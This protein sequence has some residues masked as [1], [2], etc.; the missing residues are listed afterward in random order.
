[1]AWILLDDSS[2][3]SARADAERCLLELLDL[4]SNYFPNALRCAA[5]S[6]PRWSLWK[7]AEIQGA[8]ELLVKPSSGEA[9]RR[10]LHHQTAH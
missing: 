8:H 10:I 3:G 7:Q 5:L 9:L 1:V 6:I 2:L 4:A